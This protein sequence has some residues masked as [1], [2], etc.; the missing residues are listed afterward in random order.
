MKNYS[1][2]E[3]AAVILALAGKPLHYDSDLNYIAEVIRNR[4]S[5]LTPWRSMGSHLGR[6]YDIFSLV[7][8]GMYDLVKI[9]LPR[10]QFVAEKIGE[11]NI[12]KLWIY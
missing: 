8:D 9:I 2:V 11:K 6:R 12:M 5:S 1:R 7:G 10:Q 3:I 4:K